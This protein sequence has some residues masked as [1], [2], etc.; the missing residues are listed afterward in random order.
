MLY[1]TIILIRHAV[2]PDR[3]DLRLSPMGIRNPRPNPR[4][5]VNRFF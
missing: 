3:R 1:H 4:D 2:R 5:L